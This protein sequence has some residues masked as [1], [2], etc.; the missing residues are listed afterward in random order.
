MAKILV[1]AD[2][3]LTPEKPAE[4]LWAALGRY[5]LKTRPDYIVHLGDVADFDSQ[6][7]LI[8]NRGSYTLEQELHQVKRCLEA[9][10]GPI[11]EYNVIQRAMK[12]KMYR[13]KCLLTLGNHDVRNNMTDVAD[14]FESFGWTVVDYLH[15]VQI[16]NITFA[17]C[18]SKGLSD[19]FCT[20]AQEL[21]EN[22]H[23]NI[24]V[25]HGHHKDFFE[26]YSMAIKDKITALRSP[27]FTL[28]DS[29]WAIQTQHKWSRG[30]TE[31]ITNPF[32]FIWRDC[33]CLL[34]NS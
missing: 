28:D 23:G 4:Y 3:H 16:E 1:I 18:M 12:K 26:S 29:K 30:F 15:P 7:W 34:R 11:N 21:I 33:E 17:H 25:G 5:C 9:L 19:N 22:W 2:S 20:T 24:V 13:P 31:I 8:K 10:H 27:A 32:T 14:L 6:A